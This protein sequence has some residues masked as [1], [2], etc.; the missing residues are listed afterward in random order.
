MSDNVL[1]MTGRVLEERRGG[2]FVVEVAALSRT[3]LA[4][5]AGRLFLRKIRIVPG[6]DVTLEVN[7]YD[8][9][10]GRIVYRGVRPAHEAT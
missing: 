4:R 7:A 5:A 9:G 6:D 1:T 3:V 2:L 10:R 8:P